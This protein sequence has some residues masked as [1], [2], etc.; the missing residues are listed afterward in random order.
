M[1]R[2]GYTV[3]TT[4]ASS[5]NIN[6]AN[7]NE[8]I[9]EVWAI[10]GKEREISLG[11]ILQVLFQLPK[12]QL[13]W[14]TLPTAN[15]K[16]QLFKAWKIVF[17]FPC[18]TPLRAG[19][20]LFSCFSSCPKRNCNGRPFQLQI[21]KNNFSEPEKLFF[22]FSPPDTVESRQWAFQVLFQLPKAQFAMGDPSNWKI[23]KK[24]FSGSEKLFFDFTSQNPNPQSQKGSGK[25][26]HLPTPGHML[27]HAWSHKNRENSESWWNEARK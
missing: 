6:W 3:A 11:H 24:N 23:S 4:Y 14:E 10:N 16:K 19:S 7:F 13:Q 18:Q 20:E 27:E 15:L 22:W 26:C 17:D 5:Y 12:V 1:E 21:S 25:L 8:V 2:G 9:P